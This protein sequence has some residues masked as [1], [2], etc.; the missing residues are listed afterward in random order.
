MHYL[1]LEHVLAFE[2]GDNRLGRKSA[3]DGDFV[4]VFDL[5]ISGSTS[6][7]LPFCVVGVAF[8]PFDGCVELD[9]LVQVEVRGV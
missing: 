5:F 4:K 7:D 3:T 1:A 8:D 9:V 2:F 6:A